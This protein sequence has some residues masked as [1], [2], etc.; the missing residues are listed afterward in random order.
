MRKDRDDVFNPDEPTLI[1]TYGN[2][3]KK[4]RPL[5]RDVILLGNG[6]GC[7]LNLKAAEVAPLHCLLVSPLTP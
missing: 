1:V 6:P 2:T 7:D 4:Y 5:D 3:P